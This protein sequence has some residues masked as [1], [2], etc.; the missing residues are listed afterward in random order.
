MGEKVGI[1]VN[2]PEGV[3]GN[4]TIEIDGKEYT[5]TVK[6]GVAKFELPGLSEGGKTLIVKYGSDEYYVANITTTQFKVSKVNSTIQ[7]TSKDIT[8]G[9]DETIT[10]DVPDGATGR[11]LVTINGVGYYGTIVNGKAKIVIPELKSGDYK[12]TIRY[13]GD[14]KFLPSTTTTSFKV[15]GGK[16]GSMSVSA[17][18]IVEGEDANIVVDVPKDATGDVTIE[19]GGK[20]YTQPVKNGKAKFKVPGLT[21][22]KHAIKAHYL[23]DKTYAPIDDVGSIKVKAN[24]TDPYGNNGSSDNRHHVSAASEGLSLSIYPTTI[25]IWML[26]LALLAIGSTQIRRFKK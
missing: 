3:T 13:E 26:L 8:V 19:V 1:T 24:G 20:K 15:K 18:D 23:G 10:V 2:V 9:K 17:D 4:I 25:P 16:S 6:N 14:D 12:V 7:A 11:V 21:K 22:G 5:A